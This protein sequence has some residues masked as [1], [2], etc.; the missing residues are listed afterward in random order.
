MQQCVECA[1]ASATDN[2]WSLLSRRQV[3]KLSNR[4]R[5]SN[6]AGSARRLAGTARAKA[7]RCS[8]E[9]RG[10]A[11]KKRRVMAVH[12]AG[13]LEGHDTFEDRHRRSISSSSRPSIPG[14]RRL[15]DAAKKVPTRQLPNWFVRLAARFDPSMRPLLTLLGNI[16]NATSVKAERVLG[17]KPRPREEAITATGGILEWLGIR[18]LL[19]RPDYSNIDQISASASLADTSLPSFPNSWRSPPTSIRIDL[20]IPPT[21]TGENPLA[22]MSFATTLPASG[23]SVA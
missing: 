4:S 16:R 7:A 23:W 14:K 20:L 8:C 21:L 12:V 1:A 11:G 9:F 3:S 10:L 19:L 18:R 5:A 6:S 15:G 13:D 22:V 17:W 2:F